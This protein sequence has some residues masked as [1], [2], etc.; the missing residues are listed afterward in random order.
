[1]SVALYK[2]TTN[3]IIMGE[4]G[5]EAVG[6]EGD[7]VRKLLRAAAAALPVVRPR[8]VEDTLVAKRVVDLRRHNGRV[9]PSALHLHILDA[10]NPLT[11]LRPPQ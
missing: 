3:P 7:R 6:K 2:L 10:Y 1:M 11:R 4:G 9:G 5:V 8:A